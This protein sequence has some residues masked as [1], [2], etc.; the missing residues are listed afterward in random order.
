MSEKELSGIHLINKTTFWDEC[1]S[2]LNTIIPNDLSFIKDF[3]NAKDE[4]HRIDFLNNFFPM[5]ICPWN[6][7]SNNG[8]KKSFEKLLALRRSSFFRRRIML[9]VFRIIPKKSYS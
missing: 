3:E 2:K 5:D 8:L 9:K 4:T 6:I 1:K 7:L